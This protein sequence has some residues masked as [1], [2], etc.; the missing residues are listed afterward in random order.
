MVDL[1]GWVCAFGI[2]GKELGDGILV[3]TA[4]VGIVGVKARR[5]V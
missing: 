2:V 4:G 1:G 3:A 5:V